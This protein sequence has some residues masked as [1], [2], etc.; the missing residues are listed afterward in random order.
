MKGMNIASIPAR[1]MVYIGIGL[2]IVA[3]FYVL[4]VYPSMKS[5]DALDAKIDAMQGRVEAQKALLPVYQKYVK[6]EKAYIPE[7]LPFPAREKL[8]R[9]K[10]G[11][12]A[13]ELT[14]MAERLGFTVVEI[15]PVMKSLAGKSTFVVV[16]MQLE[17]DFFNFRTFLIELGKI[18]YLETIEEIE[19]KADGEKR[20]FKMKIWL[21]VS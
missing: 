12:V 15:K 16:D 6:R 3:T 21:S 18:D 7:K 13:L 19:I 17:G 14:R 8:P 4:A 10:I 2:V 1:S 11:G 20:K 5:L 9:N